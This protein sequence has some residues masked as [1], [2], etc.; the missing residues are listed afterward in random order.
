[1][2]ILIRWDG[3]ILRMYLQVKLILPLLRL[4]SRWQIVM[5]EI[6]Y[7]YFEEN[8]ILFETPIM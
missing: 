6:L 4:L 1:M 3:F 8:S 2:V 5:Q 7:A